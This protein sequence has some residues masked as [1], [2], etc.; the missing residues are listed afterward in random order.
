MYAWTIGFFFA[1]LAFAPLLFIDRSAAWVTALVATGHVVISVVWLWL[2]GEVALLMA[3]PEFVIGA[4]L[5]FTFGFARSEPPA[6][7]LAGVFYGV[8][9]LVN[10]GLAA[11]VLLMNSGIS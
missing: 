3:A 8:A 5:G 6:F 2:G 11:L 10:T 7:R 1:T 9:V 4:L